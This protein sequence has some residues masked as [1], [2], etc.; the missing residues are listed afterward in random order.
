MLN[1][2]NTTAPLVRL[3]R[4]KINAATANTPPNRNGTRPLHRLTPAVN[5]ATAVAIIGCS[6]SRVST[7]HSSGMA[8]AHTAP[9]ASAVM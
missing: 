5:A 1:R 3:C 6:V 7:M 2:L 4:T 9:S 8:T